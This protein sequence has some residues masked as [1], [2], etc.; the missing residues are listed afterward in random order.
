V[1]TPDAVG[2]ITIAGLL[3]ELYPDGPDQEIP[4]TLVEVV[5]LKVTLDAPEQIEPE[6]EALT[7]QV[8]HATGAR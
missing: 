1:Y 7:A 8:L 2:V 4:V 6:L 3:D 5:A